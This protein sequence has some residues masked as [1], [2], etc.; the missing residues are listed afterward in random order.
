MKYLTL[1]LLFFAA[2]VFACIAP[3][4]PTTTEG[5]TWSATITN[6]F[7]NPPESSEMTVWRKPCPGTD[8][9]L[10][11]ITVEPTSGNQLI[12]SP[13]FAV[14][15][16]GTQFD[17]FRLLTVPDDLGS[18]FCNDLLVKTTLAV[19]Q[20]TSDPQWDTNAAFTLFW[21]S[22]VSIDIDAFNADA[23][24]T[25][26]LNLIDGNWANPDH[27]FS[28]SNQ[29]LMFDF[30]PSLNLMFMAWF[31]YTAIPEMPDESSNDVGS[32]DQRWLTALLTPDGN[33]LTGTLIVNEGGEFDMP[34][35]PFQGTREAGTITVEFTS[36][37]HGIVT[38]QLQQPSITGSFEI[39]PLEKNV[40][41]NGFTCS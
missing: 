22:R 36:C 41:P 20:L 31:T 27:Q 4:L 5:P 26:N 28:G 25:V 8:D 39:A 1:L 6:Q 13:S 33:T 37:E 3:P 21:D 24:Q 38:Y 15:Q 12:C 14:V 7:G 18:S 11:M 35:T 9:A 2:N 32:N 16:S 29:G 40:N 17:N 19:G 23:P 30:G 34:A 10:L